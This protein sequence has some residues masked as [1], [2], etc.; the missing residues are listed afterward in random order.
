MSYLEQSL[1]DGE[2]ALYRAHLH[3]IVLLREIL[4]GGIAGAAGIGALIAGLVRAQ[5]HEGSPAFLVIL[6]L[7]LLVSGGLFLAGGIVRRR[8]TEIVLT[9]HRVLIKTGILRRQT[10]ELL[11]SKL[12]SVG[13]NESVTG[14]MLGYGTVVLRG[15][16]GTPET[17]DRI[18]RPLE[19]RRR[20]QSQIAESAPQPLSISRW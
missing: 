20:I 8:A 4:I 9:T 7:L 15:T 12:E 16:G 5:R 3:W 2:R 18:S 11:L 6:G 14:R 10:T 1:I 13:V 19:F 17:F